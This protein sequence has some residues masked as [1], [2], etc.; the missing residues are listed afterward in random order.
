MCLRN[1]AVTT[2]QIL[3]HDCHRLILQGRVTLRIPLCA[4]HTSTCT[5]SFC[6][7]VPERSDE[8]LWDEQGAANSIGAFPFATHLNQYA[9]YL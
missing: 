9:F 5:E 6:K 1:A 2:R 3:H 8:A 7:F 4:F